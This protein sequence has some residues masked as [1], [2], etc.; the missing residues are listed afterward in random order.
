VCEEGERKSKRKRKKDRNI[1]RIKA[2]A[3]R[4]ILLVFH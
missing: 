4:M 1:D 2:V 3:E